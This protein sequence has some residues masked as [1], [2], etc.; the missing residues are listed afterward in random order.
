MKRLALICSICALG[1]IWPLGCAGQVALPDFSIIGTKWGSA[2]TLWR[3]S[4]ATTFPSQ[5]AI[6]YTPK[7]TVYGFACQYRLG[8]NTV[9]LLKAGIQAE[10][11]VPAK[12]KQRGLSLWRVEGR[13]VTVM[14]DLDERQK[15]V[16]VIA[17]SIDKNI[18]NEE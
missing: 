8:T 16:R 5:V 13:K 15:L 12:I 4:K 7:G 6:D 11:D 1:V 3:T 10:L 2:P 14:L 18:R 9:D 17:T